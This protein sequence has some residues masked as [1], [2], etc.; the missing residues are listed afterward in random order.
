[1]IFGLL[2]KHRRLYDLLSKGNLEIRVVGRNGQ[3]QS[4]RLLKRLCVIAKSP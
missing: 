3:E 4:E 2:R 1:M